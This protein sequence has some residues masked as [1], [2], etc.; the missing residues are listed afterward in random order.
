MNDDECV[1][2]AREK[3]AMGP[4][5][6]QSAL[7][8]Y[9]VSAAKTIS[10]ITIAP[11][12]LTFI[13]NWPTNSDHLSIIWRLEPSEIQKPSCLATGRRFHKS[14]LMYFV[15][16]DLHVNTCH[17]VNTASRSN[18]C[19]KTIVLRRCQQ[20]HS[21]YI[22]TMVGYMLV[23]WLR[24]SSLRSWVVLLD[25][26]V[27]THLQTLQKF[28]EGKGCGTHPGDTATWGKASAK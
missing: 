12:N 24:L 13:R 1:Y 4:A 17:N 27:L 22:Y 7:Q 11:V 21:Y 6:F 26:L 10:Q 20:N 23:T 8:A 16:G 14:T 5:F 25:S 3:P 9:K 28:P 18:S 19:S 15:H 2:H